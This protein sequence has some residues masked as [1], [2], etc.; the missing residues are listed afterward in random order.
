MCNTFTFIAIKL[1]LSIQNPFQL[2]VR[3]PIKWHQHFEKS[4]TKCLSQDGSYQWEVVQM[5]VDTITIH[6]RKLLVY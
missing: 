3:L 5:G 2:L 6:T 4:T 1:I